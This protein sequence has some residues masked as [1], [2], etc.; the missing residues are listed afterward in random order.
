MDS[1]K[2]VVSKAKVLGNGFKRWAE[3]SLCEGG[4]VRDVC[5]E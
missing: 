2:I 5:R 4:P 1:A 3:K